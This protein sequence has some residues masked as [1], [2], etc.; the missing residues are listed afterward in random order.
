LQRRVESIQTELSQTQQ[1]AAA[2][3]ARAETLEQQLAQV[4]QPPAIKRK[5]RTRKAAAPKSV[6]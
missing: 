4:R 3:H 2:Q 6:S 1:R 5:P